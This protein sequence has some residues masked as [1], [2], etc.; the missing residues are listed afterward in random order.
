MALKH[1]IAF[2]NDVHTQKTS[3]E[4]EGEKKNKLTWF[5]FVWFIYHGLSGELLRLGVLEWNASNL[6][7]PK[8]PLN[9]R[10]GETAICKGNK[11]KNYGR[12]AYEGKGPKKQEKKDRNHVCQQPG[13]K[14]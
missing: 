1:R 2:A 7:L 12:Q 10:Q 5:V 9:F 11:M 3:P 4:D 6:F 13:E 14:E 8:Q